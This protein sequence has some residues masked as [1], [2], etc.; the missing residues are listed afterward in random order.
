[1]DQVRASL[2]NSAPLTKHEQQEEK[3]ALSVCHWYDIEK[4]QELCKYVNNGSKCL[5]S[6]ANDK[7][8]ALGKG[9]LKDTL[10]GADEIKSKLNNYYTCNS[11]NWLYRFHRTFSVY[12]QKLRRR[13]QNVP[14][15]VSE[16]NRRR[17]RHHNQTES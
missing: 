12:Q 11:T 17:S 7:Y 3:N 8:K 4:L 15:S 10:C 13:R 2:N 9:I 16:R 6:C 5:E 14:K 1:M